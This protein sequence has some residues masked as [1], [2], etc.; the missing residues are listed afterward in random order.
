MQ[1]KIELGADD[2]EKMVMERFCPRLDY[3]G[4]QGPEES[5]RAMRLVDISCAEDG[6][7]MSLQFSDDPE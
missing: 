6:K 7:W 1:A 3:Y 2:I 4:P 5:K